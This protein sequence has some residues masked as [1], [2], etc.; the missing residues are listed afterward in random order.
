MIKDL[1]QKVREHGDTTAQSTQPTPATNISTQ[2]KKSIAKKQREPLSVASIKATAVQWAYY[3]STNHPDEQLPTGVISLCLGVVFGFSL[4]VIVGRWVLGEQ[5]PLPFYALALYLASTVIPFHFGEFYVAT[6]Y[7]PKVDRGIKAFMLIHSPAH[8]A[9]YAF[10]YTEFVFELLFVPDSWK[11][12][13][14]NGTFITVAAVLTLGFYS[15]RLVA[16]AQCGS[17]FSLEI[18][19][20]HRPEHVLVTHGV[21]KYLRHPSYFG[22]FWRAVISQFILMNP[23]SFV[24]F[25]AV[26]WFFFAKRI[27]FEED[28][29]GSEE[30]F[31]SK[32]AAYKKTSRIGIPFVKDC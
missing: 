13:S 19:D 12:F 25:T 20:E 9:A 4:A 16:M 5:V 2:P 1:A 8:F 22:W 17:N 23:I 28:I 31:G 30:F 7:R 6:K 24:G 15:I 21:Y 18:E 14:L 3:L 26:S 27:P 32:Y 10:S 29:L 11:L